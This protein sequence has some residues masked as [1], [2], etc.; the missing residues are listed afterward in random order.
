[1]GTVYLHDHFDENPKV[2]LA[3]EI[4][5]DAP[6]LFVRLACKATRERTAPW[7]II[8]SLS[9]SERRTLDA[10]LSTGLATADGPSVVELDIELWWCRFTAIGA[11]RVP[12]SVRAEVF[13][14]DGHCCQVCGNTEELSLDHRL[15]RSRGGSDEASNLWVL[16]MPCNMAK[17]TKTVEE[18]LS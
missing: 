17:R 13:N 18:W 3:Q 10:L 5:R 16:C 15:P 1:M 6:W 9:N 2:L 14:R 8:T 12:R 4:D 11:S 7:A